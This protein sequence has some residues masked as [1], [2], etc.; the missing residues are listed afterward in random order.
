MGPLRDR[1]L[2]PRLLPELGAAEPVEIAAAPAAPEPERGWLAALLPGLSALGM[3]GFALAVAQRADHRPVRRVAV[4]SAVAACGP[5]VISVVGGSGCGRNGPDRY[6]PTC[7]LHATLLADRGRTQREYA[8]AAHPAPAAA[9]FAA[10]RA[11]LGASG[12]DED[13]LRVRLGV[14]RA[15]AHRP[16]RF[17]APQKTRTGIR[18]AGPRAAVVLRAARSRRRPTRQR[19]TSRGRPRS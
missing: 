1:P 19:S 7:E 15:P 11:A 3:L 4:L 6:L 10:R 5:P 16:P 13:D 8:F 18:T 9:G 12:T 2:C 14:G 17:R